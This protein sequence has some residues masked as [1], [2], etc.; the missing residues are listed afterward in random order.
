MRHLLYIS[1]I[2]LLGTSCQNSGSRKAVPVSDIHEVVVD[3]VLQ[4]GSYTYLHVNERGM[5]KWLSVPSMIASAGDTYY[6]VGGLVMENFESKDLNRTFES[7]LFLEQVYST[8]P[9]PQTQETASGSPHTGAVEAEK[10][11]FSVETAEGGITIAEL[12]SDKK[13]YDGKTVRIR[14]AVTKF[15]P[16]IMDKNWIH[17][18][19]GTDHDGIFDLTVTSGQMV[20]PGATIT[21]EGK[22]SL[23]KDFGFGYFY[24]VIME[25]AEIVGD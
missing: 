5:E 17:L 4:A 3:E 24:E 18:Q 9:Q 6:Y 11:N 22:I 7:V 14:G 25:D 2:I 21:V 15:N 23:D 12:F 19:D 10:M 16:A 13:A 8:P 20:E 1:I